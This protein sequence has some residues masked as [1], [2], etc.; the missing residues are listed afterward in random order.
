VENLFDFN[1][2]LLKRNQNT[3]ENSFDL[4][5]H[6]GDLIKTVKFETDDPKKPQTLLELMQ[7]V[8][9]SGT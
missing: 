8:L 5:S 2:T 3:L 4:V 1:P 9:T 7:S 6:F